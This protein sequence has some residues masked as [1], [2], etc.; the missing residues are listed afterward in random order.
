MVLTILNYLNI[1]IYKNWTHV[2][3]LW[4]EQLRAVALVSFHWH[5]SSLRNALVY[6][7]KI[8]RSL[9]FPK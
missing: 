9:L 4:C 1:L 2:H 5:T 7:K 6:G 8:H 3:F